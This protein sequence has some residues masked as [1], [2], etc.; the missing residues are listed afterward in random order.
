M[1][2]DE[3][4]STLFFLLSAQCPIKLTLITLF[5]IKFCT[6]ASTIFRT[7]F[8]YFISMSIK[9]TLIYILLCSSSSRELL[10]MVFKFLLSDGF[11]YQLG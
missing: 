10:L 5:K 8:D 6:R 4:E 11:T 3:Q 9:L 7:H 1:L 2:S